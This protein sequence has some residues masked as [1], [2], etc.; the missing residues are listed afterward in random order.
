MGPFNSNYNRLQDVIGEVTFSKPFGFMEAG[1]DIHGAFNL[2]DTSLRS[3]A[4]VGY[5]PWLYWANVRLA[6]IIGN[7]L[8]VLG[9]Q[10]G[11]LTFAAKAIKERKERGT[12]HDDILEQLFQVQ[13]DKPELD[14]ICVTSMVA[15]NIFA[16]SD[17][18]AGSASA[19]I[20]HI[21]K[22]P[23]YRE[24]LVAEIDEVAKA[25]NIKHGDIFPIE[26]ANNMPYLQ[27]A[28][29]EAV[30]CHPAVGMNLGRVVPPQGVEI[31]GTYL[32]GGV[33]FSSILRSR[34]FCGN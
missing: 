7:R 9:R 32:P 3:A 6:P 4:W 18:T 26:V 12:D 19:F 29:Q 28:L 22:N 17:S 20:Y 25:N 14:D 1:E 30:R 24:K 13:K 2:I 23:Q 34:S 5:V 11:L 15:S 27:A 33:R 8:G 10:N 21:V 16:G 31:D